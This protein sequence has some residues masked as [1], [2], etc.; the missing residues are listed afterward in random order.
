MNDRIED[1]GFV[2]IVFSALL[3]H[4]WTCEAHLHPVFLSESSLLENCKLTLLRGSGPG[5][6]N[7][8]KVE[9]AVELVHLPSGC[10]GQAS[11]RR[12]QKENRDVALHRLREQLALHLRDDP[13]D[14]GLA[15]TNRYTDGQ[16]RINVS[17]SNWDWPVV[18][19]EVLNRL[20][21]HEWELQPL[22]VELKSTTSQII[23]LLRKTHSAM[24]LVNSH[25]RSLGRSALR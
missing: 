17:E 2:D 8:N 21:R 4:P 23:K 1:A 24:E 25:R 20:E 9:T 6:Q 13:S 11:E 5:G 12:S 18:L 16:G 19:A 3:P 15:I 7:R 22:A 14:E 10:R